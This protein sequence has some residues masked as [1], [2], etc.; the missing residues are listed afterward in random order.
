[1]SSSTPSISSS[2][3]TCSLTF[4]RGTSRMRAAAAKPLARTASTKERM[5][6]IWSIDGREVRVS[7]HRQQQLAAQRARIERE[8]AQAAHMGRPPSYSYNVPTEA[9]RRR[10]ACESAKAWR[11]AQRRNLSLNRTYEQLSALDRGVRQQ[12]KGSPVAGA[13]PGVVFSAL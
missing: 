6:S 10:Q 11:D 2:A 1:M 7:R 9:Q 5:H 13:V 4:E 3:G 8:Q 12:C